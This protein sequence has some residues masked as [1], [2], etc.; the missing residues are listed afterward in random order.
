MSSAY[1]HKPDLR[2]VRV[3]TLG[4]YYGLILFF[5]V[6]SL[7]ALDSVRPGSFAIWL[8]QVLP[9]L[10]F[11]WGLHRNNSRI[12][13]WFSLVVL[14]YFIHGVQVAFDPTRQLQGIIESVLCVL[15]FSSLMLAI[16]RFRVEPQ[17]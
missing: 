4:F 13:M 8:L 14:L 7:L 11:A 5:G 2:A 15:L 9:L 10:P 16:R 12:Y 17:D 3:A 1:S 6:V